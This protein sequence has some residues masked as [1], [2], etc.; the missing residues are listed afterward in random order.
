MK[1]AQVVG[2][3]PPDLGGMGA[4]AES[5]ARGL[6]QRGYSVTVFCLAYG[7]TPYQDKQF[8]FTVQRLRPVVRLGR[9][10]AAPALLNRLKGFDIIHLHYPWY[11]GAEWAALAARLWRCPLVVTYHMDAVPRGLL[12]RLIQWG[13][14]V[15]WPR[16]IFGAAAAVLTVDLDHFK[17]ARWWQVVAAARVQE[18]PPAVDTIGWTRKTAWPDAIID[19]FDKKTILFVGNLFAFKRLDLLLRAVAGLSDQAARLVVIGEGEELHRCQ[20]LA[21]ALGLKGRVRWLG[22]VAD[23]RTLAGYYSAAAV[24]VVP[25]DSGESFSLVSLEA[26]ACEGLVAASALPGVR[27]RVEPGVD[28]WLF[29]P[30]SVESLAQALYQA[31]ALTPER[32]RLMGAQAR[33]Q[34]VAEHSL[35][36]H[37]DKLEAVYRSVVSR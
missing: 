6:V 22:A 25:A 23:Q 19:W 33:A 7:G 37:L 36:K 1:V 29:T 16:L 13:Y 28:G 12:K 31:L 30:G 2:T 5:E 17:H 18:L 34:V 21:A 15:V 4:V 14:E 8:P 24:T 27:R 26:R 11:G 3:F 32:R 10:G 35:E 20:N 9:A